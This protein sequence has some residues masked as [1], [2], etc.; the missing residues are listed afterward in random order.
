MAL[1]IICKSELTDVLVA[2]VV[3]TVQTSAAGG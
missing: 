3:A 1:D 2:L